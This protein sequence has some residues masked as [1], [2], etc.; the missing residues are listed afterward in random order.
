MSGRRPL[1]G[2]H[3][4]TAH[5]RRDLKLLLDRL[6]CCHLQFETR[7]RYRLHDRPCRFRQSPRGS[8]RDLRHSFMKTDT[9]DD[10]LKRAK[11]MCIRPIAGLGRLRH[12]PAIAIHLLAPECF[13]TILPLADSRLS[14][15]L[16][17]STIEKRNML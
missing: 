3:H 2:R 10:S 1:T 9:R 6:H 16:T 15:G 8:R 12:M 17:Q 7:P 11:K 4:E 13:I 14:P 5:F